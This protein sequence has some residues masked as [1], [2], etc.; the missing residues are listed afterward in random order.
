[1]LMNWT[2]DF[3]PAIRRDPY[4]RRRSRKGAYRIS[5]P[6]TAETTYSTSSLQ[7]QCWN[8]ENLG[9]FVG[10]DANLNFNEDVPD[11]RGDN[12]NFGLPD[13]PGDDLPGRG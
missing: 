5:S 1:M 7:I 10:F 13:Q 6:T 11:E 3:R 8:M 4:K 9:D 12:A 2:L